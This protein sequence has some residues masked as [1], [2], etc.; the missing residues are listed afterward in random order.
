MTIGNKK[1][2][3]PDAMPDGS[4]V[5]EYRFLPNQPTRIAWVHLL[6]PAMM[7]QACVATCSSQHSPDIVILHCASLTAAPQVNHIS[8]TSRQTRA[9]KY[10][11]VKALGH[12]L[13][14]FSWRR[15][16]VLLQARIS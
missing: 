10:L 12:R 11:I 8:L 14:G 16:P 3:Q 1:L 5:A 9:Q 15:S 7:C 13:M 6:D 4:H 2:L